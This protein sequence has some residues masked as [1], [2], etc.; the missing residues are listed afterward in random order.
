MSKDRA[1][2][3]SP[4]RRKPLFF[5]D[6]PNKMELRWLD[7]LP[8][9][10]KQVAVHANPQ[11]LE[12]IVAVA[13]TMNQQ[14]YTDNLSEVGD[15]THVDTDALES[16]IAYYNDELAHPSVPSL[17]ELDSGCQR[18]MFNN[19]AESIRLTIP[20]KVPF[21]NEDYAVVA[22]TDHPS[23]SC[24]LRSKQKH[25]AELEIIRTRWGAS[26]LSG[27]IQWIAVGQKSIV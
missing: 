4:T 26:H 25:A 11:H 16:A 12:E 19:P 21:V 6:N 8:R 5:V 22:M 7:E 27:S 20:F 2:R 14:K 18:F 13:S 9:K 17:S 24:V 23:C 15:P 1:K 3:R 10:R